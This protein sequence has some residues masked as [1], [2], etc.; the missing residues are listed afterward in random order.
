M[1]ADL[2]GGVW[3]YLILIVFGFLPSE[4][5]RIIAVFVSRGF[6]ERSEIIVWVRAVAT[7]LVAGVV[8]K[9]L[10]APTGALVAVPLGWRLGSLVLGLAAFFAARRSVMVGVVVGEA[11]LI[12]A[13]WWIAR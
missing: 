11:A 7:A 8:A 6:D 2:F 9:I 5:W 1:S 3:P 13:A 4:V 12:C 10:F